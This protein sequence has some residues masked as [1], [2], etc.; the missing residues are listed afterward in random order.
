M[1]IAEE[2]KKRS[3]GRQKKARVKRRK[4]SEKKVTFS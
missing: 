4:R 3:A 1:S 2:G